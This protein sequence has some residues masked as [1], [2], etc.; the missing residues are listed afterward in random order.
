MKEQPKL[1]Y[2][3]HVH[4]AGNNYDRWGNYVKPKMLNRF[5]I[6]HFIQKLG[7]KGRKIEDIRDLE[8]QIADN[9]KSLISVSAIFNNL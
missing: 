2:D 9:M 1:T 3:I 8:A 4:V 7:I 6:K 5:L